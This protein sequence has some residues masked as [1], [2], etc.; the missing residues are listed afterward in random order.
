[1]IGRTLSHY[2]ITEELGK[3]AMG[4]VY[5]AQC[6]KLHRI[7]ALKF[8]H[9]ADPRF[10][11]EARIA[12][13]LNHANICTIYEI[14]EYEGRLFIAMEHVDGQTLDSRLRGDPLSLDQTLDI[15]IQ[16][17]DGLREAH[18][19]GAIHRDIK[20]A[21]IMLTRR[22]HVKIMDFGLAK[23]LGRKPS[24]TAGL[25]V[26]TIAY[27]SP[28]QARG[29]DVDQRT[30]IWSTGVV[31][32][33]MVTGRLPFGSS[34]EEAAVH[35]IL[36][37]DPEPITTVRADAPPELER[38][39]RKTLAKSPD[40]RYQNADALG[41]ELESL[42][43]CLGPHASRGSAA[44]GQRPSIAVL[45]FADMSP[46]RDQ[47]YFCEGIAEELINALAKLD[48][49]KV[50]ARTSAFQFKD[51]S[52]PIHKIGRQ[53]QVDTVLEGSV[54]QAGNRL[55]VSV[56]L[57]NVDDGFHMWSEKYDRDVEDIFAIQDEI[58]L[59][60]VDKLK[61][62]LLGGERSALVKRYT[63]NEHAHSLYLKGRFFWNR[64]IEMAMQYFI[65]AVEADPKYALAYVGMADTYNT[66]GF[67]GYISPE[68]AFPRAKA[69]AAK[70]LKIDS[71][72]GAAH[73]SLGFSATFYDWDWQVAER[74]FERAL[75]LDR[76]YAPA[77]E[78][79]GLLLSAT[80]RFDEAIQSGKRALEL[81][82][83]SL[84]INAVVGIFYYMAG[85]H[86]ECI[87]QQERALLMEPNY[88]LSYV[89][90]AL[91]YVEKK[92]FTEAVA[93]MRRAEVLVGDNSYALAHFGWAYGVSGEEADAK[94]I[95]DGLNELSN[96]RYVAPAH[97]ALVYAGL[98][99]RDEAYEQLE[100]ACLERDALMVN[101]KS[102][103]MID[104]LHANRFKALYK[105][106]GL[107]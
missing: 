85:R 26:G 104:S 13:G 2:N 41:R 79:Y 101:I 98:G 8:P 24:T 38:I 56:Q 33:Q 6:T 60:I 46:L 37:E 25:P 40:N 70:A 73:A 54:R 87:E 94:R 80:G 68:E 105:K 65:D 30:D 86:D 83:L 43:S 53:L 88:L 64:R 71:S 32:Y 96:E 82:P 92:M 93:T 47:D 7:V 39:V 29:G 42:R 102:V 18:E 22:G 61:V 34:R 103:P 78:W 50:A 48:G 15:A 77:H 52:T 100:R 58:S 75:E 72:L 62:K 31:L 81:E 74:E 36:H 28:E 59:A 69:A 49:L 35:L 76:N 23:L 1:M 20:P 67:F 19:K 4:V 55:R 99:Q 57:V 14:D 17:A 27:M 91:A 12:A 9:E 3:G 11:R 21:N 10:I 44:T 51:H 16:V 5:K 45:R 107:D 63:D 90:L 84:V 95:L 66:L 97:K 89:F 106:F